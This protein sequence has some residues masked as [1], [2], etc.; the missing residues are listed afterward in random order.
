MKYVANITG[1]LL[2]YH[3]TRNICQNLKHTYGYISTYLLYFGK[4]KWKETE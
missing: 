1:I 3:H 4:Q 2:V